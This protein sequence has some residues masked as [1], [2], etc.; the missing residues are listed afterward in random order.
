MKREKRKSEK[1]GLE[2]GERRVTCCV[3]EEKESGRRQHTE[4]T[5]L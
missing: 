1:F 4:L 3:S 5:K 2:K